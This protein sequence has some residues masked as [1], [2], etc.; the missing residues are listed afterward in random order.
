MEGMTP[1]KITV[2]RELEK[3]ISQAPE[4]K[5]VVISFFASDFDFMKEIFRLANRLGK[6][7]RLYGRAM[8]ENFA[9]GQDIKWWED[10]ST[11]NLVT[12]DED[13][14][15]ATGTQGE[16]GSAGQRAGIEEG[17]LTIRKNDI[18]IN[19]SRPIPGNEDQFL[20]MTA[21][22]VGLGATVILDDRI[23]LPAELDQKVKRAR[24]H[25][26]GH[27]AQGDIDLAIWLTKPRYVIPLH[28]NAQGIEFFR[29]LAVKRHFELLLL[30]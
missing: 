1:P 27:G 15:I 19:F 10:D 18:V 8:K 29:Q 9:L 7:V 16:P 30:K 25:V 28:P 14:S 2:V 3:I 24:L 17:P 21:N 4:G 13:I 5:R 6:T 11:P 26:S 23:S 12:Q 20:E 22:H